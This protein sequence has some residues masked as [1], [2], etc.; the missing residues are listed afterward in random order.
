MQRRQ[1]SL[2]LSAAVALAAVAMFTNGPPGAAQSGPKKTDSLYVGDEANNTVQR[3]TAPMGAFRD[4]FVPPGAGGLAGP[5]GMIFDHP[6]HLLVV[7]QNVD[8]SIPGEILRFNG[9]TGGFLGALVSSSDPNA[10][11]SPRGM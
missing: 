3:F 7:N 1:F 2:R 8:Q 11:F 10:P 9:E 4:V 5:R 6:G